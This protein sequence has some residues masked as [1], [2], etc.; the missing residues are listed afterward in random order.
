MMKASSLAFKRSSSIPSTA[1]TYRT[2]RM[3]KF[4]YSKK[5]RTFG[6]FSL[7][8]SSTKTAWADYAPVMVQKRRFVRVVHL[9]GLLLVVL[10][11]SRRS[12]HS[13]RDTYVR[14]QSMS[15]DS[16]I[17]DVSGPDTLCYQLPCIRIQHVTVTDDLLARGAPDESLRAA[18]DGHLR[19]VLGTRAASTS[20]AHLQSIASIRKHIIVSF[21][22][23]SFDDLIGGAL[24]QRPRGKKHGRKWQTPF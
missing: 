11:I 12:I 6:T 20:P 13:G 10:P 8:M 1:K 9:N 4:A 2:N 3:T 22:L 15:V 23:C 17:D 7:A 14:D 19:S 24:P 18:D 21:F 5:D 16:G